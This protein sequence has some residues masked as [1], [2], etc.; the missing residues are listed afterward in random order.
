MTSTQNANIFIHGSFANSQSWKKILKKIGQKNF[1]YLVELP[2]HGGTNDPDDFDNPSLEPE[3]ATIKEK[4]NNTDAQEKDLH[5]IGHS[6]GGVVALGAAMQHALPVKRLTLFEPVDV[7]VLSVFGEV[8]AANEITQFM[9]DH[10][11]A[12]DSDE[13]TAC[14]RVI[15]FW[16][17]KGSYKKIPSHIQQQM[18]SMTKKQHAALGKLLEKR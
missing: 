6:Y 8:D 18:V 12:A 9:T 15:D 4:L 1:N 14:E 7:S 13:V 2:G 3:I 5:L 17:G 10:K 11:D 16:G